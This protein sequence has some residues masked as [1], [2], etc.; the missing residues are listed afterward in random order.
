MTES[1]T[2]DEMMRDEFFKGLSKEELG[3]YIK[4]LNQTALRPNNDL[5][6]VSKIGSQIIA[7][8]LFAQKNGITAE[9]LHLDQD[10]ITAAKA[11]INAGRKANVELRKQKVKKNNAVQDQNAPKKETKKKVQPKIT[12]KAIMSER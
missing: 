8:T 4:G 9:Q 6:T 7:A 2:Q 12:K 11:N 3:A 1:R 5:Q 10:D